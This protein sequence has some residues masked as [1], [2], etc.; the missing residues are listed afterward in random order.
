MVES[1][2]VVGWGGRMEILPKKRNRKIL[3][4][5]KYI[6]DYYMITY[7]ASIDEINSSIYLWLLF[8]LS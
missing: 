2:C 8:A 7:I 4:C 3:L 5:A 1:G 6:F